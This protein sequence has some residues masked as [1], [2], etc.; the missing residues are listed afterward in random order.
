M[1]NRSVPLWIVSGGFLAFHLW[2]FPAQA[3]LPKAVTVGS[4]PPGSLFYALASGLSKVVTEGSPI[5]AQVQPHAGTSTFLP[6]INSGEM[7]F[8]VVN[9]VDMGLA[10][11]GPN[12]LKIGGRNPFP[13]VPNTR[14]I[15]RG[16]PLRSSLIVRKDSPIK[17]IQDVKGKRV[18]GEYPA[19]LAVW[20]N[21]FGSLSNGGLTWNDVKV[22]PVP[23]VN[24]GV[25]ALVQGRADV[26]T[27][28]I[29][30]AKV[31]EAD[32]AVGIRY[33]SLDCSPEG[34]ARIKK[35]V[36]GYYLTVV[37]AGSSTGIVEDTCTYTYDIYLV[38]HKGLSD[39]AVQA[40]LGAIWDN[41]AKLPP[42]H[43]GF[44]E[45]T[46]E[47]A[48]SPE[49]TMPYHPAAVQFFKG[50][51]AWSVKAEENQQRLLALNP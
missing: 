31:K 11:Q 19:Q 46:R 49:A 21:V 22:V 33:I 30:S 43:P 38:G 18:T 35:A 25:D 26:T 29:G 15:M 8:G 39:A 23:A 45:W 34:E 42:L 13:H 24:E 40:V 7:D 10:Y 14:L 17:T 6:L 12:R 4:N 41:I 51:K 20:Y 37:K 50:K 48:V 47:R 2:T 32:A 1:R 36:P 3:Q 9:A 27:H 16:S 5:Q 44:R 28:A